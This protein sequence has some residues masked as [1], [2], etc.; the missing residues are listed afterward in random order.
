MIAVALASDFV[1]ETQ[2]QAYNSKISKSKGEQSGH[3]HSHQLNL[4]VLG[5]G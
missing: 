5:P 3:T 2:V 1:S 4:M